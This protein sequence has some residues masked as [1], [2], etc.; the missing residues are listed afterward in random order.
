MYSR[1]YFFTLIVLLYGNYSIAQQE[2]KIAL[3]QLGFYPKA[4]K[5]AVVTKDVAATT[6]QVINTETKSVVY[7]GA[8][9]ETK[10]SANSVLKTKQAN[11][12]ALQTPGTYVIRVSG[13][14]ES[15]TFKIKSAVNHS[16]A[17]ASLKGFYFIRSNMPLIEK[18]AGK[19]ARP[20]GHP[21]TKVLVHASAVSEKRPE[22]TIFS[23]PG[24]WY[25][26][27]DYNKYIVNS[28]IST[29][30]L[31]SAYEDF[32]SYYDR[33]N[34]NI[35]ESDNKVPDVLDE[36]VYNLRWMLTMQDPNDGGVYHKCTNADFDALNS[37]PG[38]TKLPRYVVQKGTSATLNFAAVTAQASRI[39][40]K[41][42]NSLPGL[43]DSCLGASEKAW[44]WA[45]LNPAI[46]YNQRVMNTKFEPQITT[47]DYGDR[48]LTDEWF[49]A[50]SELFATTKNAS[51]FVDVKK[52]FTDPYSLPSWNEVRMLGYYTL[53]RN[54][55]VIPLGDKALADTL[56]NRIVKLADKFISNVPAN[57]FATVMGQSKRD[58][59]W[60]SSAVACNQGIVLINAYKLT[61]DKQYIN[62]ALSN[63]DY[64]LGRNATGYSFLTGIGSKPVMHPHH[65]PSVAD[66]V[67]DPVP[68]LLS[69]GP[70]PGMQD[71]VKYDFS[72]PE[73][74]FADKDESYASNE[75][76]INWNAPLAY[77]ANAIEAL[78]TEI[79]SE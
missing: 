55:N 6:F 21:D 3:N 67:K 12:S 53:T 22:G 35:P 18:Y 15:Y 14:P 25:D 59:I 24:G 60:G 13:L 19:W 39:L 51:Y 5:I 52:G 71:K 37:K 4:P 27:G 57:A 63:L 41:F 73:T 72:E 48:K 9:S 62:Y 30:T 65:R 23:S 10:N 43:S 75:I 76:A 26:A 64:I 45:K 42:E 31:F 79:S 34:I 1:K 17:A 77:L 78:Q 16:A 56:K 29:S 49:W 2:Q 38:D 32:P 40:R 69:G 61:G 58:F 50:A 66:N 47:G 68:G 28:G 20:A 7:K 8:L 11:F 33:L 54:I 46:E 36:A 70:N 44:Q 74:A